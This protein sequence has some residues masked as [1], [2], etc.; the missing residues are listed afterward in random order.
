MLSDVKNATG[1]RVGFLPAAGPQPEGERLAQ[2]PAAYKSLV[3]F[4]G[5][6]ISNASFVSLYI[7]GV[8]PSDIDTMQAWLGSYAAHL[9]GTDPETP[10][11]MAPTI[12]QY[13][14]HGATVGPF[15]RWSAIG[16]NPWTPMG[17]PISDSAPVLASNADGRLEVFAMGTDGALWH[18]WQT[19]PNDG[20]S[21]WAS[22]GGQVT[23]VAAVGRNADERLEVFVTGTD[24]ALWHIWQTAPNN[25]WSGW[26]SLGGILRSDPAVGR[27]E[28]GRLEVFAAGTDGAPWHI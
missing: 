7:G 18:N 28:D 24:G 21:G 3:N 2:A 4:G 23:G 25:G 6:T 12:A 5:P 26:A 16:W 13:G 22:L 10:P 19:A 11:N 15:V 1:Q 9:S 27:N 8:S 14:I 20:W 17:G